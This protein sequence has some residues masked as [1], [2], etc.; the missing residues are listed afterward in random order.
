MLISIRQEENDINSNERMTQMLRV[1]D[2]RR[3]I[4]VIKK[5]LTFDH[6]RRAEEHP[7]TMLDTL[8]MAKTRRYNDK[9][10][11]YAGGVFF[12]GLG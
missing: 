10:Y 5:W 9:Y 11:I 1:N 2:K 4:K 6:G 3:S 8:S 7:H 12:A